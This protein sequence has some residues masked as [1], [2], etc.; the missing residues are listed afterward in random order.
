MIDTITKNLFI[1]IILKLCS[2]FSTRE[3]AKSLI[4]IID[5]VKKNLRSLKVL[6]LPTEHWDALIIHMVSSTLDPISSREWEEKRSK[7]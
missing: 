2:V 3:S 4:Y 5:I 7:F 1:I 6:N